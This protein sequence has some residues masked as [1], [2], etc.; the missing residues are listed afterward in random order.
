MLGAI[1]RS[2][3]VPF[4]VA[5][6]P[7]VRG[8]VLESLRGVGWQLGSS[9]CSRVGMFSVPVHRCRRFLIPALRECS[10]ANS[11][12]D[13]I[14]SVRLLCRG[15]SFHRVHPRV[16]PRTGGLMS[17]LFLV[18][19]ILHRFLLALG[20]SGDSGATAG[21]SVAHPRRGERLACA[22]RR[23]ASRGVPAVGVTRR[24]SATRSFRDGLPLGRRSPTARLRWFC[25]RSPGAVH[26][27]VRGE[28]GTSVV[29]RQAGSISFRPAL[30]LR[31]PLGSSSARPCGPGA[32]VSVGSDLLN[33]HV[34]ASPSARSSCVEV[35]C[36]SGLFRHVAEA[37]RGRSRAVRRGVSAVLRVRALVVSLLRGS[38]VWRQ[39]LLP[40]NVNHFGRFG[41]GLS[42]KVSTATESGGNG[43]LK[44]EPLGHVKR[45]PQF[46]QS[47]SC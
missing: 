11:A 44:R 13:W 32:A 12:S 29:R 2:R 17:L 1:G 37:R 16:H 38:V 8:V 19:S 24:G 5:A 15:L 33:N 9:P 22:A 45:D 42:S 18:Y 34:G 20:R 27:S 21:V 3:T 10:S 39:V 31:S 35:W 47:A 43:N 28:L 23:R 6:S 4:P 46:R 26:A 25:V 30:V 36:S 41:K 14:G 40:L 7:L